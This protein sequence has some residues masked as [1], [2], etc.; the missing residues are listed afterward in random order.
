[1]GWASHCPYVVSGGMAPAL[2]QVFHR[3]DFA[4]HEQDKTSQSPEVHLQLEFC[5]QAILGFIDCHFCLL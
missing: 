2:C 4:I 5:L 3:L 1:M